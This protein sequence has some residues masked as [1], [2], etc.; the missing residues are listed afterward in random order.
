MLYLHNFTS[1]YDKQDFYKNSAYHMFDDTKVSGVRGYMDEEAG[2]YLLSEIKDYGKLSAIHFLDSG[3]F[4]HLSRLY[5]DLIDEPFNLVVYDN[6]TDMQFSAFGNILSCGSWIADA[7]ETHEKLSRIFIIG[8]DKK[9]IEDC[10]FNN[11]ERIIFADNIIKADLDNRL[12]I[13]LSVDKDVLSKEEFNSDWDQGRMSLPVLINEL[14]YLADKIHI[15]GIDI[16]GEPDINDDFNI[17]LSNN[18][19][20]E[21]INI[22]VDILYKI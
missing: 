6:H 11:N 21:L 17:S 5:L 1:I 3:N 8:A 22:F 12:P 2:E 7:Y 10:E 16:C 4:H 18:I 20:M 14:K 9:Y 13:Y 19:N 15:L